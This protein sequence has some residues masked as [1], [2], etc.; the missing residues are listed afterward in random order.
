LTNRGKEL[1]HQVLKH[2]AAT[3]CLPATARGHSARCLLTQLLVEAGVEVSG[4]IKR[5]RDKRDIR[6][7]PLVIVNIRLIRESS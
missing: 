2:T 7:Q 5:R 6:G 4:K 1:I 3:A